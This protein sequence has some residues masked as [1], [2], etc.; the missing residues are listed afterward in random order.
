MKNKRRGLGKG[1]GTGYKNLAPMDSHIHSLSAKGC[2]TKNLYA[3]TDLQSRYD[4]RNSFYGKAVVDDG[5]GKLTLYSYNIKVAEIVNGQAIVYGEYSQTT[6]RHI[7]EFLKQNNFFVDNTKQVLKDYSIDKS[8]PKPKISEI[9]D[10][11]FLQSY[12]TDSF[13]GS[14]TGDAEVYIYKGHKYEIDV[15]NQTADENSNVRVNVLNA[16][17]IKSGDKVY[18][19][20]DPDKKLYF[21]YDDSK[22]KEG[23][24]SLSLEDYPDIEQDS[25]IDV[26]KIKKL[27][28]KLLKGNKLK[29]RLQ[30]LGY[31]TDDEDWDKSNDNDDGERWEE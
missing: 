20:D 29:K 6:M 15:P 25:Y 14:N 31:E 16:K 2:K 7:K 24:V 8:I 13:G 27:N 28:A 23:K 11:D 30:K 5:D 12:P 3:K 18:Y 1:L 21:V 26:K 22:I 10:G 17:G 9:K 19:K 4:S